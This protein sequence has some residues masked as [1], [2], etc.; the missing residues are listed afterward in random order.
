[1]III[2]AKTMVYKYG[3]ILPS[4]TSSVW[5]GIG[6]GDMGNWIGCQP[7]Q[8]IDLADRKLLPQ[9]QK[10]RCR[11]DIL[12]GLTLAQ[13]ID[14]EI[15]R[16]RKADRADCRQQHHKHGAIRQRHQRW[17]RNASAGTKHIFTIA[18]PYPTALAIGILDRKIVIIEHLR[19]LGAQESIEFC[20]SHSRCRHGSPS[21]YSSEHSG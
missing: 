4:K 21:N 17:S 2:I 9:F 8:Q 11:N 18:L 6:R 10:P 16:D 3:V 1:M 14:V 15:C 20:R 19:K 5:N 13:K 12:P 7:R